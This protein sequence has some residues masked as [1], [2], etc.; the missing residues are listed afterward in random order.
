M[1]NAHKLSKG[2]GSHKGRIM[3]RL[4]T[5]LLQPFK[6][7]VSKNVEIKQTAKI[8]GGQRLKWTRYF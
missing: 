7:T 1:M 4:L 8:L 3:N 6:P 5:S 2:I